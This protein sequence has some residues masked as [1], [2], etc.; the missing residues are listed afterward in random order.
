V[1]QVGTKVYL[2]GWKNQNKSVALGTIVSCDPTQKLEGVQVG[3][4]FWMVRVSF[5]MVDDE[6]LIRPY[7]GYKVIG[8]VGGVTVA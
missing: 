1:N 3:K 8:D 4:E 2:Q 7:K 5:A 6:P